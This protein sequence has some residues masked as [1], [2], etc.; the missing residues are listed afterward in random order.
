MVI[1]NPN[2]RI[3]KLNKLTDEE[4]SDL[5][6]RVFTTGDGEL[7]LEHL[8]IAFWEYS[9]PV[10][11]T[12]HMTGVGVGQQSVIIHIKNMLVQIQLKP[13]GSEHDEPGT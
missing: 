10:G 4:I 2:G 12:K 13:K 11:N 5:Y 3:D 9:P 1:D 8:K 7:V 6:K